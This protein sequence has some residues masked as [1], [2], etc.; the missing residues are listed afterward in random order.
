LE[1]LTYAQQ[2]LHHPWLSGKNASDHNL[3]PE[4]KAYM[5]KARLRRGIEIVK[6]AN[7]IEAL[8]MQEDETEDVPGQADVPADAKAAAGDAL[9]GQ[10][11]GKGLETST[12]AGSSAG[13][14]RSLSNIAKGAI[15]RE[16]VLAKVR[17]AKEQEQ[18]LKVEKDLEDKAKR[19]SF[20]G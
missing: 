19:N 16:V 12:D 14:K 7:R 17:E 3:L 1:I 5:A 8:K 20:Q 2:A 11:G 10:D 9:S 15:F 13:G 4:I 18:T 6:L